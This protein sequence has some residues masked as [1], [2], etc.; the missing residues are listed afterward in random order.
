MENNYWGAVTGSHGG[1][2]INYVLSVVLMTE[3]SY[4]KTTD[5]QLLIL[6]KKTYFSYFLRLKWKTIFLQTRLN[7]YFWMENELLN[8]LQRLDF[9]PIFLC[10]KSTTVY[11]IKLWSLFKVN[12]V[13][14]K[15]TKSGSERRQYCYLWT[16]SSCYFYCGIGT[17]K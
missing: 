7:I 4:R 12:N 16:N 6:L 13:C 8:N 3:F 14:T 11:W 2:L 5:I 1:V 9:R 15:L 17:S 10:S